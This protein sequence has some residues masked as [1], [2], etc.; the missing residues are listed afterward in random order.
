MASYY[1]TR[2]TPDPGRT[3]VWRAIINYL[4]KYIGSSCDAVIDIGC[5]YGDFI[6]N[7]MAKTRYAI[8]LNPDAAGY[9]AEPVH[10][11]ST[12]VT[13]LSCIADASIDV[14][15][16]S[17]LLE[18]LSDDELAVAA[19]EF[20]RILRPGGLFIT[21]QPNFYYAYRE[22]F[23]DFTHKKVFSHESL[24]DFFRANE[25]ELVA[26]EK[27]FLPFSLRSRLPKTYFLTRMYLASFYR[28]SAKQMLG[29]FRKSIGA[30]STAKEVS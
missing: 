19:S 13:D 16:S 21:M 9:L 8:D 7:V 2:Y 29:V 26:I 10:F 14:A 15:F 22:Y 6:N 20:L 11:H 25:F 28:P 27:R 17:N 5:G 1:T 4:E 3:R 12:K 18:H 23:D 30:Q 24:V